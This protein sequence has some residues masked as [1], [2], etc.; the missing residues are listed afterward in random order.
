MFSIRLALPP[1]STPEQ[2]IP[3]GAVV[4]VGLYTID[5]RWIRGEGSYRYNCHISSVSG[6]D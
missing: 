2:G 5:N 3:P 6:R 4:E 1:I